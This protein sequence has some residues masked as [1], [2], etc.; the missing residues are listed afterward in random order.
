MASEG[1]VF[2]P[3]MY[4][5]E[6]IFYDLSLHPNYEQICNMLDRSFE[7]GHNPVHSN[8]IDECIMESFFSRMKNEMICGYE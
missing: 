5:C 1:T 7:E 6:I 8:Y 2:I 4:T 3:D